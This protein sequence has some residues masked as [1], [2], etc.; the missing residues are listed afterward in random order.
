VRKVSAAVE[1]P[2]GP[3]MPEPT[4]DKSKFDKKSGGLIK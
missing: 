3:A 2:K 1:S 4:L